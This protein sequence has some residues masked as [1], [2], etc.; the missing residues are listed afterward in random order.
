MIFRQL[1]EPLS[2]TY[3]YLLGDEHT[4]QANQ[5]VSL[6]PHFSLHEA[7]FLAWP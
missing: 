2:S 4:G 5:R 7:V 3:A 1:F 6:A